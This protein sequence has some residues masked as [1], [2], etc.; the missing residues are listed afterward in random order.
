LRSAQSESLAE[1]CA[2]KLPPIRE[3]SAPVKNYPQPRPVLHKRTTPFC[4][5][6]KQGEWSH[7][8]AI[9]DGHLEGARKNAPRKSGRN[10]NNESIMEWG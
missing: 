8:N 7:R 6:F 10:K 2:E 1:D 5:A 9:L 3:T 4:A